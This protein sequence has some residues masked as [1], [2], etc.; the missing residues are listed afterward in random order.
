MKGYEESYKNKY[1]EIT[2]DWNYST[3]KSV[4]VSELEFTFG[5]E[6]FSQTERIP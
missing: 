4:P 1:K 3:L 6:N 2:K 5:L